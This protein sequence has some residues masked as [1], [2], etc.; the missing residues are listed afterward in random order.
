M[1]SIDIFLL[2]S[3][4]I[5]KGHQL[6]TDVF[7]AIDSEQNFFNFFRELIISIYS[8]SHIF[9][10]KFV[11]VTFFLKKLLNTAMLI[12]RKILMRENFLFLHTFVESTLSFG[13]NVDLTEKMLIRVIAEGLG[14]RP[15]PE[16]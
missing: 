12:S 3:L 11:K 2:L 15:R 9:D 16:A 10:K 13:I 8:L 6:V 4:P 1:I 5:A 14:R 7:D